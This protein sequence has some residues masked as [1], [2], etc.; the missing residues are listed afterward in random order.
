[1]I[2]KIY[3]DSSEEALSH[4]SDMGCLWLLAVCG[5][6]LLCSSC[7]TLSVASLFCMLGVCLSCLVVLLGDPVARFRVSESLH[8]MQSDTSV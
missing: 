6:E 1:M 3:V 8:V 7:A 5:A 4:L 2:V